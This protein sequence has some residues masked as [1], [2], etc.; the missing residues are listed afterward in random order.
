MIAGRFFR[1]L[2]MVLALLAPAMLHAQKKPA[3]PLEPEKPALWLVEGGKSTAWLFGTVHSLPRGVDW[4][5]PH[6]AKALDSSKRLIVETEIPDS[7]S[8]VLPVVMRISRQQQPVPVSSRVPADWQPVL[9]R[10]VDR[11]KPGPL[12][13]YKTWFVA[14][15]LTN[16]QSME[17]GLDPRIGVEAV[18]AERARLRN[19]PIQPLETVEEQLIYF[20][21]LSE[22]D[23]R[24]LLLSTL[25]DLENSKTETSLLIGNWLQGNIEALAARVNGNFERSPML[26]QLLV[27]DRNQRWADWLARELKANN[28]PVFVA[29]GAGHLAGKGSLIEELERRGFKVTRVTPE[30]AEPPKR[31][32]R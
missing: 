14:L 1:V 17:D 13:W 31:R 24:Q 15:T 12:E 29:V 32:R 27:E 7:P 11:L 4:F 19:I 20:D 16:L 18:L 23:Q 25:E 5:R 28:G 2:L 26:R 10:A 3:A 9:T 30:P 8:S 21:A 6:V 22:A